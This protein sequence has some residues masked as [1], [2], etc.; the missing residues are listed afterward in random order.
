MGRQALRGDTYVDVVPWLC[1]ATCPEIECHYLVCSDTDHLNWRSA[2]TLDG[3]LG[4]A[5]GIT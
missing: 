1:A 3:V 4:G 2:R 5:A